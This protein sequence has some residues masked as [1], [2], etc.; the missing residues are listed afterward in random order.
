VGLLKGPLVLHII[1][2]SIVGI[3]SS[4]KIVAGLVKSCEVEASSH[5]INQEIVYA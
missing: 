3:I 4:T 2:S 1:N 5:K